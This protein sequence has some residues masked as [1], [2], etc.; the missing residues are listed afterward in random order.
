MSTYPQVPVRMDTMGLP[1]TTVSVLINED[2]LATVASQLDTL[3]RVIAQYG[4]QA[5]WGEPD[6]EPP[7][8]TACSEVRG[9]A[10]IRVLQLPHLEGV[11]DAL[12]QH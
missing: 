3:E 6:A 9:Q 8:Q 2:S 11:H 5:F 12:S 4:A 7:R 10:C 1:L